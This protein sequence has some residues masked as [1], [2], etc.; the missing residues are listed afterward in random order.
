MTARLI[1][2]LCLLAPRAFA[3]GPD[4]VFKAMSDELSRS[5]ARLEMEKLGKPYF[6]AYTVMDTDR[7]S[8][9]ASFG[10]LKDP[11]R[12][13][14][15]AVR[16]ELRL[17][18]PA[19]DN[20]HYVGRDYW[21][22]SPHSRSLALDEDYDALRFGLW[23]VTDEAYKAGL[24][25]LSQKRAY[26]KA[27]NISEVHPDL[28]RDPVES[29][30]LPVPA[31][32]LDQALWEDRARRLSALFKSYPS[33]QTSSV[34]VFWTLQ[35]ARFLDSE[36]RRTI[37]PAHDFEVFMEATAQAPDGMPLSDRR[38][39]LRQRLQDIPPLAE[40]EAQARGLAEDLTALAKA[41]VMEPYTGPVLFEG[42]AAGE[43]FNQLL[44][45]NVTA[46]RSLWV[47]DEE[48]EKE[49]PSGRLAGKLGMRVA[50]PLLSAVD[51]PSLAEAAGIPL[52]GRYE[53]DD[54]GIRARRVTLIEGG[55]L[56]DVLMSRS[57]V[58]ERALSNGHGRCAWGE[59][60]VSRIGN[61]VIQ[62]SPSVPAA[63]LRKQLTRAAAEFGLSFGLLVRR[64]AEEELAEKD[65][66]LAPP[67]LVYKVRVA[68]GRE[69]LVRSASFAGVTLRALRD[70]AAAS[71]EPRAYNYYQLGPYKSSRGQVQASI[72]HPDVLLAEMELKKTDKKPERLPYL[73]HP[74]F[75][76][77]R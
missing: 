33:V 58:K 51:D 30:E 4:P 75:E 22:F 28:S 47:E 37:R 3:A 66:L 27:R 11:H 45:R 12:V 8:L 60:C 2:A 59:P 56:K 7:L 46:P 44:A 52:L 64:V 54:Q 65:D 55:T 53:V 1:L 17:G 73:G 43:L 71:D 9:E 41:P 74:R 24:Q 77:S 69:E 72:V 63:E 70:V 39:V 50:S 61:L 68:D 15:R 32:A 21:T 42:Q 76:R 25:K 19:F 48:A 10:R 20:A 14:S 62:A 31:P 35:T 6:L 18:S 26:Q 38:R 67:V 23:W 49:F 5:L 36:G 16:V 57:P 13:R 29:F 34:K 40:L